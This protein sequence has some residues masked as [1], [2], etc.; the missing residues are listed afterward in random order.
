MG[1]PI[2]GHMLGLDSSPSA[3]LSEASWTQRSAQHSSTHRGLSGSQSEAHA[4][5]RV[6]GWGGECRVWVAVMVTERN[7]D[8]LL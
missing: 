1:C 5:R 7:M 8:E 6:A 3:L 2:L 4:E